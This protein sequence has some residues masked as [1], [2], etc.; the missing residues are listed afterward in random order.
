MLEEVLCP[1]PTWVRGMCSVCKDLEG[2]RP[3]LLTVESDG[4][5]EGWSQVQLM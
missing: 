5:Q 4:T 1:S 2:E 3:W